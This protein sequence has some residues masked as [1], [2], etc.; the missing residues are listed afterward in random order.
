MRRV[1]LIAVVFVAA[2]IMTAGTSQP[3]HAEN[4]E[5]DAENTVTVE[6]GDTLSKI[7]KAHDTTYQRIYYANTDIEHPDLIYPGD[8]LRIPAPDETL[9]ERPI[10]TTVVISRPS[11]KKRSTSSNRSEPRQ[12]GARNQAKVIVNFTVTGG[13]AWDRLAACESGG[14]WHINTGNGYYGGLQFSLSSWQAVGGSG[15]PHQASKSEQIHR[16][17]MLRARQGWG[18]WPACSAKLGLR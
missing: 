18:A 9:A 12:Y 14:N 1:A 15:Y 5:T 2:V 17:E 16:A 11:I 7:A 6:Q 8:E 13:E 3:A 4:S 10:P